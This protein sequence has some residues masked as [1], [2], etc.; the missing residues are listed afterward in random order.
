[1]VHHAGEIPRL[2]FDASGRSRAL[3][4]QSQFKGREGKSR[5]PRANLP[6]K[7][8]RARLGG[9]GASSPPLRKR[10][11][12]IGCPE[13]VLV[14]FLSYLEIESSRTKIADM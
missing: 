4:S 6:A 5:E 11:Y 10:L 3:F 13:I 2:T 12:G 7:V 8:R 1:M 9:A 14:P